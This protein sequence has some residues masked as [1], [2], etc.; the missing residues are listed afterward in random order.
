M[1]FGGKLQ[2]R[3]NQATF[4]RATLVVL[5]LAGA[6]LLRRGLMM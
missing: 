4:R 2:D 3:I 1:W 6:N 5:L